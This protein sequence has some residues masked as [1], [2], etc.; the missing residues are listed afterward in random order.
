MGYTQSSILAM[1]SSY[2][3]WSSAP[4]AAAV[5]EGKYSC[6]A[7]WALWMAFCMSPMLPLAAVPRTCAVDG[8]GTSIRYE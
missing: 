8:S 1:T 5:V 4:R 2:H 6:C 3:F 7:L